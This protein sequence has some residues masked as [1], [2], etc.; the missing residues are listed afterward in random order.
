MTRRLLAGLVAV[1]V[2]PAAVPAVAGA[3]APARI[4]LASADTLF[5]DLGAARG[6]ARAVA[7]R[8]LRSYAPRLGVDASDIRLDTV[9]HSLV[10]THVR[11]TEVRDGV[12]VAGTYALVSIVGGRVVQVAARDSDLPGTAVA[13]PVSA[14]VAVTSA[15]RAARVTSTVVPSRATRLL[16]AKD[17]RL[18]DTYRVGVLS[19]KPAVALTYDVAAADGRVL[20]VR[21]D[22]RYVDGSATVFDPNP[23]VTSRNTKLRQTGV[24]Q[25]GVDT[26]L[27]SAELAKQLRTLPLKQ[28]DPTMLAAGRLVG[29]WVTIHGP[30]GPSV[31]GKFA[32]TRGDPRFEATMAYAH[33][34]RIQRYFQSL[35][36]RPD[37]ETGAN[38]ESQDVV[39]TRVEGFD[40]SFYQPANDVMLLGTGGVDDGE[41]AEVIIHEYGHAV[42]DDQVPGWG[43]AHEGGS[44]G[45]GF[46]D[47]LAAAY[48]ARTSG[49]FGDACVADWDATSYSTANPPCLRRM[50]SRKRYPADLENEVHADGELW[51]AL[52]W[53]V[54]NN[55]GRNAVQKSDNAIKLVLTS[56]EFLTPSAEFGDAVAALRQAAR[57]LKQPTWA[58]YVDAAARASGMPL[59]P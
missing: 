44:M 54:R 21:D 18:V 52:L 25:L 2:L 22:K 59:N 15:L 31:D 16:V 33:I 48:Y 42:Q 20:A 26:D 19:L 30:V 32:F 36:F 28:L 6:D 39:T 38:A 17:G 12:P 13:S 43:D 10:G 47:F 55:L 56:H 29:P 37:R 57:A 8:A 46:G 35:G 24:D 14:A 41:D 45:E 58:R 4:D 11:G 51:S 53:R 23:V 27:D 9:R 1:A 5:G 50:D 3:P 49:G 7:A 34:D 40:N